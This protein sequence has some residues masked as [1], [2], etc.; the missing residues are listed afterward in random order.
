M[1]SQARGLTSAAKVVK[2]SGFSVNTLY[3]ANSFA[4]TALSR[5]C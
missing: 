3:P 4:Q 2:F 1:S 5:F